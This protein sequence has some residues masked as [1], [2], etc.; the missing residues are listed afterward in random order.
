MRLT[1][2]ARATGAFGPP[3]SGPILAADCARQAVARLRDGRLAEVGGNHVTSLFDPHAREVVEEIVSFT[4]GRSP[5]D[6]PHL[7]SGGLVVSALGLGCMGMSDFYGPAD[8][9]ESVAMVGAALDGGITL[10]DTG[11]YYGMGH[12]ELLLREALRGRTREQAV[13][14]VK[15]GV[16]R[17]PDG[18]IVGNDLRPAAVKNSLAYT[19]RRLG[20]DYVD[21]YRPGRIFPAPVRRGDGGSD[22]RA[23]RRG[24]RPADR[25]LGGRC[26][27]DPACKRRPSDLGRADRVLAAV[28]RD[29]G[30]DP[31]RVPRARNRDHGPG[32]LSRGL[33]GGHWSKERAESLSP[34]DFRA[35]APRFAAENLDRNL[36]LVETLR[37]LGEAKNATV[38]QLAIAWSSRG[39]DV[40]SSAR[41]R[42]RRRGA[43]RAR[44][45]A[46]GRRPGRDR[47]GDP[48]RKAA[49]GERHQQEQLATLDSERSATKDCRLDLILNAPSSGA[50][51]P[52]L[53]SRPAAVDHERLARDQRGGGEQ[54]NTT[55]PATSSGSPTRC[56]AAMRSSTSARK[57]GSRAPAPFPACG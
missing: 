41:S 7:G 37:E 47:G 56:S 34:R 44:P 39:D 24:L 3:G 18:S 25:S 20:T 6:H 57:S 31:A 16:M 5:D 13:L 36:A 48:G 22:R 42:E 46:D 10:L 11:D 28:A 38:A 23:G 17:A 26:R 2:L 40:A 14:S 30:R 45:R 9:A 53:P 52:D 33:L 8:D 29:R 50:S 51:R 49:A 27:D 43:R 55:A 32:V 15:F 54:R 12:N 19:L 35:S 21:I 1:L 4:I